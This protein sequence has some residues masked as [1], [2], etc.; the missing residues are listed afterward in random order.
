[1]V[2][3]VRTPR[4]VWEFGAF[5]RPAHAMANFYIWARAWPWYTPLFP[6]ERVEILTGHA[7]QQ[8][9]A[10]LA[11]EWNA[12]SPGQLVE[13]RRKRRAA[14]RVVPRLG[15]GTASTETTN[16]RDALECGD[17]VQSEIVATAVFAGWAEEPWGSFPQQ[18]WLGGLWPTDATYIHA[19][20]VQSVAEDIVSALKRRVP[21]V[22]VVRGARDCQAIVRY[23][24]VSDEA[25]P[26]V[27]KALIRRAHEDF[28][29]RRD[30]SMAWAARVADEAHRV[31]AVLLE[32]E[33]SK[34]AVPAKVLA[35]SRVP[36]GADPADAVSRLSDP[37]VAER[38]RGLKPP[39]NRI[40]LQGFIVACESDAT[41]DRW[42]ATEKHHD[43]LQ[44]NSPDLLPG[45]TLD[46]PSTWMTYVRK[47]IHKV[48]GEQPRGTPEESVTFPGDFGHPRSRGMREDL[49]HAATQAPHLYARAES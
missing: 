19:T 9:L 23:G 3:R 4:S 33:K 11:D 20:S 12:A 31:A 26:T 27:D 44:R 5:D 39:C 22:P 8:E 1:M 30:A 41:L 24:V 46:I 28:V 48:L 10:R 17:D 29:E 38:M 35:A 47:G 43:W 7:L 42:Q 21:T 45:K 36:V 32:F 2:G 49:R 25:L 18:E 15:R 13:F 37:K 16:D 34:P 40:A 6:F 14:E